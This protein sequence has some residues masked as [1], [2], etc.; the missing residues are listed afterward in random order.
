MNIIKRFLYCIFVLLF[1]Q[2]GAFAAQFSDDFS[3]DTTGNYTVVDTW[4]AG[5]TGQFLYDAGGERLQVL[6]GQV[7][8]GNDIGLQFS[9]SLSPIDTGQFRIDFLPTQKYPSGGI[10][11]IRLLEDPNNYYELRNSDGYGPKEVTKYVSGTAVDTA[12]FQFEYVQ[13]IDYSIVINFSPSQTTVSA[14]GE[15][16]VL[17]TDS[18]A[19]TVSSFE[20]E[21]TQQDAYFDNLLYTNDTTPPVW[22]TT[23][24]I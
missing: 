16:L 24:G 20:I 15:Q 13:S 23:V 9:K 11:K 6:T 3:T 5:G 1:F 10:I 21:L 19:I 2:F 14:F 8:T 17:N 7:L 18:S 12:V 4:T 22:D